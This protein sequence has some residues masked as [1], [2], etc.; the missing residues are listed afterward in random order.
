M[1][2]TVPG[3]PVVFPDVAGA[4]A[5]G[6]NNAIREIQL[7]TLGNEFKRQQ[8][9][10][11]T[12]QE[13][14]A[15]GQYD[16]EQHATLLEQNGMF[17]QAF[18]LRQ[19]VDEAK[20]RKADNTFKQVERYGKALDIV[21]KTVPLI[22]TQE[23]YDNFRAG[24]EQTGI[25]PAGILPQVY[26][27]QARETLLKLGG[28]AQAT[29]ELLTGKQAQQLGFPQGTVLQRDQK[30]NALKVLFKPERKLLTPEEEAQ[31]IRIRRAGKG[32]VNVSVNTGEKAFA[33]EFGKVNARQF[34]ERRQAAL[35]AAQTLESNR[36]ARRLLDSGMITGTGAEF[37]LNAGK[38]LRTLG[39]D[40]A[41]DD[42]ANT[43]AFV[44]QRAKEVGRIIKLFGA[45]TGLSD[46]DR[47]FAMKAAAGDIS[48]TEQ[49]MRKILDIADR[50]S[51]NVIERF[52][53]DA[54]EID[55]QMSPFPL[56]VDVPT[57]AA[58]EVDQASAPGSAVQVQ[59]V[60]VGRTVINRQTGERMMWD[61]QQ[62]V[63]AQ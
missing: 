3:A 42:I 30:T 53:R 58:P 63:P 12:A 56:T 50:A 22:R 23:Q 34:F 48:L 27:D 59:P 39:F 5:K 9:L 15:G 19:L 14:A 38:L 51:M 10:E 7:R 55:P 6:L 4:R 45:G 43:E 20:T 44:A 13:A 60:A 11:R 16:P 33:Q 46:A 47:E 40:V 37:L 2:I 26:D 25:I 41:K 49:S 17:Q 31:K 29:Y 21:A 18:K 54:K 1:P 32:D 8:V 61:G 52:N 28:N 35:D 36:Q 62:W 57:H 24:L